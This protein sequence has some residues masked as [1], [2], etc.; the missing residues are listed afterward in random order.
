V[1]LSRQPAGRSRSS[2]HN[3]LELF[4]MFAGASVPRT[5]EAGEPEG[6][7]GDAVGDNAAARGS[8]RHWCTPVSGF[9]K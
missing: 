1:V 8:S 2:R 7:C 4:H 5:E 3:G 6:H 9:N